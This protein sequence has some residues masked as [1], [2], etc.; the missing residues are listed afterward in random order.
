MYSEEHNLLRDSISDVL[1]NY[2]GPSKLRTHTLLVSEV[3]ELGWPGLVIAEDFEGSGMDVTAACIL[4]EEIGRN[5]T[6]SPVLA[7]AIIP[8]YIIQQTGSNDQKK[9]WLPRIANGKSLISTNIGRAS[10]V[11]RGRRIESGITLSGEAD[12][13]PD[14]NTADTLLLFARTEEENVL[15]LLPKDT[16]SLNCKGYTTLDE[17]NYGIANLNHTEI[18]PHNIITN[19]NIAHITAF[20]ALI[21]AA[22]QYGSAASAF[23]LTLEYLK[24]RKQFGARIGSYQA[25]QHRAAIMYAELHMTESLILKASLALEQSLP[26]AEKLC[27]MAKA[28]AGTVSTLVANESIQLHGGIGV[29]DEYDVGLYLKRIAVSEKMYGDSNFHTNRV[30]TLSGF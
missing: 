30:A 25:L 11:V 6:L 8:S 27:S 17:R 20:G 19:I 9:H 23:D 16:D 10:S 18:K 4:A 5:V 2:S 24:Q 22:E 21:Y 1:K 7:S 12:F 14:L 28:K 26:A 29:T 15:C 13:M 3:A